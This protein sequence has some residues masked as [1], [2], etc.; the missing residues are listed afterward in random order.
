MYYFGGQNGEDLI[1]VFAS[2]STNFNEGYFP[3]VGQGL[4]FQD[5][6]LSLLIIH[7]FLVS[8]QYFNNI[9]SSVL[10]DLLHPLLC[11]N[12]GYYLCWWMIAHQLPNRLVLCLRHLC[13]K[14]VQ[15][16]DIFIGRPCPRFGIWCDGLKYGVALFWNQRRSLR[17][18][19]VWMCF[20]NSGSGCLSCL[21]RSLRL[22]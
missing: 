22:L 16:C 15:C 10:I 9:V 14:S 17:C 7:I 4:P 12:H 5:L 11:N 3:S 6:H 2:F 18:S 13:S 19:L 1:D 8:H 20:S 21:R